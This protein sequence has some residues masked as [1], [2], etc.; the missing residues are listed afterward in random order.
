MHWKKVKSQRVRERK[1]RERNEV[2]RMRMKYGRIVSWRI[3]FYNFSFLHLKLLLFLSRDKS[4]WN[5][6]AIYYIWLPKRKKKLKLRM[7]E[8]MRMIW[9]EIESKCRYLSLSPKKTKRYRFN[10][11]SARTVHRSGLVI[12][13]LFIN[14]I[15]FISFSP[16]WK[17]KNGTPFKRKKC[18]TGMP[19][20]WRGLALACMACHFHTKWER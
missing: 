5:S 12:Q 7:D 15:H 3:I 18:T 6:V 16:F 11:Y 13:K 1:K 17:N 4:L 10:F 2:R 19:V 20:A 14:Y 9:W 8:R